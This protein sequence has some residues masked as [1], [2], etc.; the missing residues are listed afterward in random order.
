[1]FENAAL[2]H[3]IDLKKSVMIGDNLCDIEAASYC[4]MESVL[5]LTG[6]GKKANVS[7]NINPTYVSE[8]LFSASKILR[9]FQ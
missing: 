7:P 2:D 4:K 5:V 8:N 3:K 1:M 9:D 6:K